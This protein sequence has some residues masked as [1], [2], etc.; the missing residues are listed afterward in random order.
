MHARSCARRPHRLISRCPTAIHI[1]LRQGQI[2]TSPLLTF[3]KAYCRRS[4]LPVSPPRAIPVPVPV[5]AVPV[6]SPPSHRSVQT[7]P[8]EEI[9]QSQAIPHAPRSNELGRGSEEEWRIEEREGVTT[10][11]E[12]AHAGSRVVW[13]GAGG[14]REGA[15][16]GPVQ[17][18]GV[19]LRA[20]ERRNPVR[21]HLRVRGIDE[22]YGDASTIHS[23]A[24]FAL[25]RQI[26]LA[27][28]PT[29]E[30]HDYQLD[31]VCK[32]LDKIDLVAVTPTGSGKTGFI[33]LSLLVMMAI[34]KRVLVSPSTRLKK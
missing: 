22:E 27:A 17:H 32:I 21:M 6:P 33:F 28:L 16:C 4:I 15:Q 29:F 25:V 12:D 8:E 19:R 9:A 30:P 7:H 18:G 24:G 2:A 14:E 11:C 23:P 3:S 20:K 31:G 10:K 26:L 5:P 13:R 34:E 1:R